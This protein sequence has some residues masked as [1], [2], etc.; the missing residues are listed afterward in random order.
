MTKQGEGKRLRRMFRVFWRTYELPVIWSVAVVAYLLGCWGFAEYFHQTGERVSVFEILYRSLRLF[1]L[2]GDPFERP[3][4]WTLELS[5]FLAPTLTAV[6]AIATLSK[7]FHRQ[8]QMLGLRFRRPQAVV[9]GLGR[10]GLRLVRDLKAEAKKV[11]VIERDEQNDHLDLCRDLGAV[12]VMGDAAE[13]ETLRLAR[14]HRADCVFATCGDD[15]A[16]VEIAV[17][18]YELYMALSEH[19]RRHLDCRLHIVDPI[20]CEALK[21]HGMFRN[22]E[23][24]FDVRVTN[25]FENSARLLLE[26]H[27][28]DREFIGAADPRT[29]H[30]VIVGFGQMG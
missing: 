2:H 11:V 26:E 23:D 19:Q 30:L 8:L 28:L 5:R 14:V 21:S 12:V 3:I 18:V 15:G 6:T 24:A 29:V 9:C 20:L 1:V 16:N 13:A 22:V 27:R 17:H 10:K 25:I 7:V 4:P